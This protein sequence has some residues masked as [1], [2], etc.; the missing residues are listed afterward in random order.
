M[1]TNIKSSAR[2]MDATRHLVRAIAGSARAVE[3]RSGISGAQLFILSQLDGSAGPLSVGEL[4]TRT[5]THQSTASGVVSALV[6][7]G[8]VTRRPARDDARRVEVALTAAGRLLLSE[9]PTTVQTQLIRGLARL[10]A[11]TRAALADALE[12]WLTESG[13]GGDVAPLFFE[14]DRPASS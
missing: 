2:I 8:L 11:P 6:A 10:D 12:A 5:F 4:A 1:G 13:L 7:R 3:A 14:P 9:A